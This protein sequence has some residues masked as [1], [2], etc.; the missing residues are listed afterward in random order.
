MKSYLINKLLEI[1][2]APKALKI[3]KKKEE[4]EWDRFYISPADH[5]QFWHTLGY[6]Y[7]FLILLVMLKF[8]G[9]S[10]PIL[11]CFT[12]SMAYLNRCELR[13]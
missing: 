2:A 10:W 12:L 3:Y 5:L 8:K 6:E 13:D 7:V 4:L 1:Y 9:L 11:G